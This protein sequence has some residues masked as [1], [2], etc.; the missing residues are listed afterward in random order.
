MLL[1]FVSPCSSAVMCPKGIYDD[2][3]SLLA[4]ISSN[5]PLSTLQATE[6]EACTLYLIRYI[7]PIKFIL[8][9][10]KSV[11]MWQHCSEN[12]RH[13]HG[14]V[15]GVS[16]LILQVLQTVR[17]HCSHSPIRSTGVFPE[18]APIPV[19]GNHVLYLTTE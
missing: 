3:K 10:T 15:R 1:C 13:Y 12:Y 9:G 16:S 11:N 17:P 5:S 2:C 7:K 4:S 18:L 19:A 6:F 14:F 8:A